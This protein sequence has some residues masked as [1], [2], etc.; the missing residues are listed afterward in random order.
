MG[1]GRMADV[2]AENDKPVLLDSA[3][4]EEI[5]VGIERELEDA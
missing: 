1:A 5:L 2:P 4:G 3:A